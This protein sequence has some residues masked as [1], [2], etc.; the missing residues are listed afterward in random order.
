MSGVRER[1]VRGSASAQALGC[2]DA[3]LLTGSR[4]QGPCSVSTP[5]A[6]ADRAILLEPITMRDIHDSTPRPRILSV[7]SIPRGITLRQRQQCA[8]L[9]LASGL[10]TAGLADASVSSIHPAAEA[11]VGAARD[12]FDHTS[13][14]PSES[15]TTPVGIGGDHPATG[16]KEVSTHA[17]SDD[18][19]R[20]AP[21]SVIPEPGTWSLL[22]AGLMAIGLAVRQRS[23]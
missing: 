17:A 14:A 7:A 6:I 2:S 23:S 19:V 13:A 11:Q 5:T 1:T 20:A 9:I 21:V 3:S 12:S 22:L 15:V 4:R 8:V 16:D 10:L 18:R